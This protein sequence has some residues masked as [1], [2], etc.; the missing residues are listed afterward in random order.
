MM[1]AELSEKGTQLDEEF[2]KLS[3][4]WRKL[5]G[6]TNKYGFELVSDGSK[7]LRDRLS[8][9]Q[10]ASEFEELWIEDT[11]QQVDIIGALSNHFYGSPRMTIPDLIDTACGP[12]TYGLI[13]KGFTDYDHEAG[14]KLQEELESKD[15]LPTNTREAQ[16]IIESY[17]PK[18]KEDVL[19]FGIESGFLPQGFDLQMDLSL[20]GTNSRSY[21]D[22]NLRRFF[23]GYDYFKCYFGTDGISLNPVRAYAVAFHEVLGHAAQQ[24]RSEAMPKSLQLS[25]DNGCNIPARVVFEGV[26]MAIENL[27]YEWLR[28]NAES[29]KINPKH[30]VLEEKL[31]DHY[32]SIIQPDITLGILREREYFEGLNVREYVSRLEPC[33]RAVFRFADPVSAATFSTYPID[34]AIHE[35]CYPAG[36]RIADN[37][38]KKFEHEGDKH[39][40]HKAMTTGVWGWKTFPKAVEYFLR[41]AA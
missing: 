33:P 27:S 41:Q 40:L 31:S 4:N 12:G 9:L 2:N 30:I 25:R 22:T 24:V 8:S 3:R 20:P 17:A 39:K 21:W 10:P 5:Y 32:R 19:R 13:E 15:E 36:Y 1:N 14:W 16:L 34:R 26:A 6:I 7:K 28:Q 38:L 18:L 37:A 11:L 23:L 35:L 29:L